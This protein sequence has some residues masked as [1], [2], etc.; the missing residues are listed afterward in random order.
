MSAN[1]FIFGDIMSGEEISAA[2]LPEAVLRA[3]KARRD[4]LFC[5]SLGVL[6]PLALWGLFAP[7]S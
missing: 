1:T 4:Y 3:R 6:M 7:L 2:P 5:L